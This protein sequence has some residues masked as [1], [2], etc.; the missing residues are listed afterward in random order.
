MTQESRR[1]EIISMLQDSVSLET[2]RLAEL[3][4][5]SPVTIRRDFDYLEKQGLITTTYGGALVNRTLPELEHDEHYDAKRLLAEKRSIARA[6]A[7]LIRPG[8]TVLIDAGTTTKELAIELLAKKDVTVLTN[9]ILAINILAQGSGNVSVISLPGTFRKSSMCFFGTTTVDFLN[10]VHVDISFMATTALS[11]ESGATMH[12]PDEAL[13][14][15]KMADVAK[16][17]VLLADHTKL[18]ESSTYT[19]FDI[20]EIDVLITGSDPSEQLTQMRKA[21]VQVLAV[22]Y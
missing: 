14:K 15:R 7:E 1:K 12:D 5:V 21:G 20:S 2:N 6:A 3:F 17:V 10:F 16:K 4:E 9:S 19:A 13:V 8:M 18:G 11:I 22:D